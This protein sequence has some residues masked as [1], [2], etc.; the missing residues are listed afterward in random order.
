MACGTPM[1]SF[2]IGG[3]PELVRM[4]CTGYLAQPENIS[5]MT[6]GII[7]LLEDTNLRAKIEV[8]N[9]ESL[10]VLSTQ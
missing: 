10:L 1:V 6:K 9:A 3:I 8:I 4:G 5:D 7:E 2:N